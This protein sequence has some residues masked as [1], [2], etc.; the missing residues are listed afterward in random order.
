MA[1]S[2]TVTF[3]GK[4]YNIGDFKL[5]ELAYIEEQLGAPLDQIP[6]SS[7]KTAIAFITVLKRREDPSFT[8]EQ[9]GEMTLSVLNVDDAEDVAG[10]PPTSSGDAG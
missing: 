10:D 8:P 1:Q 4:T 5:S 7:M 9:A 6:L 3:D 2:P